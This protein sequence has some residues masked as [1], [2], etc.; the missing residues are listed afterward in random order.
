M[1]FFWLEIKMIL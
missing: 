1:V